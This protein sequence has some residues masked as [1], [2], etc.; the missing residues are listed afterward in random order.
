VLS[1]THPTVKQAVAV[2]FAMIPSAYNDTSVQSQP[3]LNGGSRNEGSRR[4]SRRG[5]KSHD[6]V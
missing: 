2:C 6:A 4:R 5:W 1:G 3:P